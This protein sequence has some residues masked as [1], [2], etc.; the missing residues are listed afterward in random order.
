MLLG[1]QGVAS[2][3]WH[4]RMGVSGCLP[5]P[6]GALCPPEDPLY[7]EDAAEEGS[8]PGEDLLNLHHRLRPR[9]D[10]ARD[11]DPCEVAVRPSHLG[12]LRPPPTHG[13]GTPLPLDRCASVL[14]CFGRSYRDEG[15]GQWQLLFSPSSFEGVGRGSTRGFAPCPLSGVPLAKGL[16]PIPVML[17]PSEGSPPHPWGPTHVPPTQ[18]VLQLG[19][20]DGEQPV[21]LLLFLP[22]SI[23]RA[24]GGCPSP[25]LTPWPPKEGCEGGPCPPGLPQHVSPSVRH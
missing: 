19:E 13:H 15:T 7:L 10:A 2:T 12:R 20:G 24:I 6:R 3:Q 4:H 1:C 21:L 17:V 14:P 9:L 5:S 8:S 16:P 18:R 23:P 25:R 22:A 11:A